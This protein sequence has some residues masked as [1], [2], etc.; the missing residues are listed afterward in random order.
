MDEQMNSIS[1]LTMREVSVIEELSGQSISS[2]ANTSSP[3]GK[4][5]AAMAYVMGRRSNPDL[6]FDEALDMDFSTVQ[7]L[8]GLDDEEDP[9]GS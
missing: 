8:L 6:T 1:N 3:Q 7:A 4:A 5:L 9:K 2:L